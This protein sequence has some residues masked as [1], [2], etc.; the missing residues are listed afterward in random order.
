MSKAC[1]ELSQWFYFVHGCAVVDRLLLDEEADL[2]VR[3][4]AEHSSGFLQVRHRFFTP[5]RVRRGVD[6]CP[7]GQTGGQV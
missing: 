6:D 5:L 3:H 2:I 4:G 7:Q 1:T